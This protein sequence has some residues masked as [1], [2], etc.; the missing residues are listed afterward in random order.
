MTSRRPGTESDEPQMA[1]YVPWY[2]KKREQLARREQELCR[3]LQ[4]GGSERQ[5]TRAAEEVRASRIRAL[6]AER[7]RI[8][9]CDG[10]HTARLTEIDD[11]IRLCESTPIDAIIAKYRGKRSSQERAER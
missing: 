10:P 2:G 9:Q 7:A 1:S 8:P 6:K 11:E 3:I 4:R 5:L